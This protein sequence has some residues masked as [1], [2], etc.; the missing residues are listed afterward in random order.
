MSDE[1]DDGR[2]LS[3]KGIPRS[4]YARWE[5]AA[6]RH[7]LPLSRW[8]RLALKAAANDETGRI[9]VIRPGENQ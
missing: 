5:A 2:Q 6:E 8:V 9:L 3:V 1:K 4:E 7:G